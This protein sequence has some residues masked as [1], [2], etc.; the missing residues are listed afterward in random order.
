MKTTFLTVTYT[1]IA[2]LLFISAIANYAFYNGYYIAKAV[3]VKT[4]SQSDRKAMN[5]KVA[6]IVKGDYLETVQ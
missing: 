2:T 5:D 6:N 3:E 1:I 4:Y